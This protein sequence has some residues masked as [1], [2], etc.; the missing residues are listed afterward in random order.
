MAYSQAQGDGCEL[1]ASV[2]GP[3][4]RVRVRVRI[5]SVRLPFVRVRVRVRIASVRLPF[6]TAL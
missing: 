4:V 6:C 5:A 2:R 3:F 1:I